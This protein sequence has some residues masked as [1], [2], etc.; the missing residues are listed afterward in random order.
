MKKFLTAL[1]IVI[2]LSSVSYGATSNDVYVRQDVFDAK[3]EALFARLDAKIETFGA[4]VDRKIAKLD[5]KIEAFRSEI[6]AKIEKLDAKIAGLDAKIV[7][8]DAKIDGVEARMNEKF[9]SL[10]KRMDFMSNFIYYLFVLLAALIILPPVSRWLEAR[11]EAKKFLT[12]EDVMK[13]IEE[14]DA[15]LNMMSKPQAA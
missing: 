12:V 2:A 13:L 11:K 15:K 9:T 1:L 6:N 14:H 7:G 3:M 10:E 8:L 4:E 5:A